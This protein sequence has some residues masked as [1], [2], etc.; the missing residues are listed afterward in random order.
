[1]PAAAARP[2]HTARPLPFPAPT[3]REDVRAHNAT[4]LH[5]HRQQRT[6]GNVVYPVHMQHDAGA[7]GPAAATAAAKWL[8]DPDFHD[9]THVAIG[10]RV[11]FVATVD[12]AKGT[13]NS[14]MGTVIAIRLAAAAPS[15]MVLPEGERWVKAVK[16]KLDG[17]GDRCAWVRR[18]TTATHYH[19]GKPIVKRTF[20]IILAYAM[21]AHRAQGATIEGV[22]IVH[23][24]KGFVPGIVYVILSRATKRENVFVLGGLRAEDFVPVAAAEFVAGE[25]DD[26]GGGAAEMQG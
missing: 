18:T 2:A 3:H 1:V 9:L 7:A 14:A 23:V 10:A 22:C 16:V 11:M 13:T 21:T 26:E 5:W 15:G 4:A 17:P 12:K 20:P 6:V 25:S 8:A 19:Q 24:R